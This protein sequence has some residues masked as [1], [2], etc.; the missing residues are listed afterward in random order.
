MK[1]FKGW[2]MCTLRLAILLPF[3]IYESFLRLFV[4][5]SD[6]FYLT[7]NIIYF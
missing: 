2:I 1:I 7:Q 6:F 4:H 3:K 5:E